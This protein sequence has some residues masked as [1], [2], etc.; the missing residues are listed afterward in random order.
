MAKHSSKMACNITAANA[1]NGEAQHSRAQQSG[2]A[3]QS[4]A[5]SRLHSSSEKQRGAACTEVT[6][7][8]QEINDQP[9]CDSDQATIRSTKGGGSCKQPQRQ[10]LQERERQSRQTA[11]AR[12]W[13]TI[14]G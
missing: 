14:E 1:R 9:P 6:K 10:D 3:H 11:A 13:L 4:T 2:E 5:S 7:Q 12:Q 8:N